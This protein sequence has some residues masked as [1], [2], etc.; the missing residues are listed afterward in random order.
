MYGYKCSLLFR[1]RFSYSK[2]ITPV[3]MHRN[4]VRRIGSE[5]SFDT[6]RSLYISGEKKNPINFLI[7]LVSLCLNAGA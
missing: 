1:V 3:E 7:S 6:V 2:R 5:R 4:A